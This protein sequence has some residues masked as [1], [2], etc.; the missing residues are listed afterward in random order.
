MFQL[1]SLLKWCCF[2]KHFLGRQTLSLVL[3]RPGAGSGPGN[4]QSEDIVAAG[5]AGAALGLRSSLWPSG[6]FATCRRSR[7]RC[8][9]LGLGP[10]PEPLSQMVSHGP[11]Q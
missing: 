4:S 1:P 5:A 7:W 10:E 6:K 8:D 9:R 11:R 3:A 2:Q